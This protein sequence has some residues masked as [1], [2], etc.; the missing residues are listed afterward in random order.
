LQALFWWPR[1]VTPMAVAQDALKRRACHNPQQL[2]PHQRDIVNYSIF[3]PYSPLFK[4][5]NLQGVIDQY[6]SLPP[7]RNKPFSS[8]P[9]P[10]INRLMSCHS[11]P[12]LKIAT[13][14]STTAYPQP[15][16]TCSISSGE[17]SLKAGVAFLPQDPW[18][19]RT[20]LIACQESPRQTLVVDVQIASS[21][22]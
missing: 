20:T 15:R 3:L 11:Q 8:F 5:K 2:R 19:A 9:L 4:C 13:R 16:G 21:Q 22:P 7:G 12:A 17:R 10:L 6:R 18:I 14:S 1:T